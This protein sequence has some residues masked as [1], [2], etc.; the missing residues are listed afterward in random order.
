MQIEKEV[1]AAYYNKNEL[2]K[3]YLRKSKI[4]TEEWFL[5]KLFVFTAKFALHR[6]TA[7]V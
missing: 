5:L 2:I 6:A 7:L 1:I 3:E 4:K